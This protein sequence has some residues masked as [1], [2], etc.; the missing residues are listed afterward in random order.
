MKVNGRR[1]AA[2][3]LIM[4]RYWLVKTE[5]D[6]FS[7]DDLAKAPRQTTFWDGVRNY[8]A[9]N[10]MRAMRLRDGVLFYHSSVVPPAIVGTAVVAREAYPDHTALDPRNDHYDP[11]ASAENPI[12]EIVDIK[13]DQIFAR[14]LP[15]DELR[16][17]KQLAK[18][19]L[20]RRG[21]RLSVQP[22][23]DAEWNAVLKLAE[24]SPA[25]ARTAA[26]KSGGVS[27][28]GATHAKRKTG[29]KK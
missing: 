8:Q 19:E 4:R 22:V 11:K 26:T 7:I 9:R 25:E 24:N 18:M 21:S 10:F 12:W 27:R 3:E 16:N 1:V 28:K 23:S 13:L 6:C 17:V 14:P 29:G 15:L 5:P 20:L 2:T